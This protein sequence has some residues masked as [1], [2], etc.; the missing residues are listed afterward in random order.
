M[1]VNNFVI[2]NQEQL[3]RNIY[4]KGPVKSLIRSDNISHLGN[5]CLAIAFKCPIFSRLSQLF[6][7]ESIIEWGWEND[8]M[9]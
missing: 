8:I 2:H 1:E 4:Y 7:G 6:I 3:R 9:A 5:D